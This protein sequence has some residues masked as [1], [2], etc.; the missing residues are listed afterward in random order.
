MKI[1]PDKLD[2]TV[3]GAATRRDEW[4]GGAGGRVTARNIG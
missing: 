4:A 1:L 3:G 2:K